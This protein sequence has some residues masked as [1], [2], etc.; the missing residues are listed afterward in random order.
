MTS[1]VEATSVVRCQLTEDNCERLVNLVDWLEID[2]NT[3]GCRLSGVCVE[4]SIEKVVIPVL[5]SREAKSW[6]GNAEESHNRTK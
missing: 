5:E 6:I 3:M 1:G 4:C 2:I